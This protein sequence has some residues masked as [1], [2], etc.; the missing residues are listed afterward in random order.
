MKK[1]ANK[2][3]IDE[4]DKNKFEAVKR[5]FETLDLNLSYFEFLLKSK[6]FEKIKTLSKRYYEKD[7]VNLDLLEREFYNEFHRLQMN[8][9]NS[10]L[11]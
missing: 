10:V 5:H 1:V 11:N 2:R 9:Q 6:I 4:V 8:W 3:C 7:L